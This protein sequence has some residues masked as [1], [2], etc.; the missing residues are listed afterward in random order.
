MTGG[1]VRNDHRSS[2]ATVSKRARRASAIGLGFALVAACGRASG[3][4]ALARRGWARSKRLAAIKAA[5]GLAALWA[6]RNPKLGRCSAH[7]STTAG[8]CTSRS[9]RAWPSA[10]KRGSTL[11]SP[12]NSPRAPRRGLAPAPHQPRRRLE[13]LVGRKESPRVRAFF[14]SITRQSNRRSARRRRAIEPGSGTP[15]PPPRHLR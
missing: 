14:K 12:G 9:A 5:R 15:P 4:A 3:R 2:A 8:R 13:L 7:T 11:L 1:L 6:H 10:S